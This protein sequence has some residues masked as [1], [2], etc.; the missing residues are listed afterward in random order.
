ME[1]NV[2]VASAKRAFARAAL[3]AV[4]AGTAL[5]ASGT[6]LGANVFFDEVGDVTNVSVAN[7]DVTAAV[8]VHDH[9]F[10]GE[11]DVTV[12][13]S[14]FSNSAVGLSGGG[15]LG[16]GAH[17]LGCPEAFCLSEFMI[18]Q[19]STRSN[20]GGPGNSIADLVIQFSSDPE[21]NNFGCTTFSVGCRVFENG[22]IQDVTSFLSLPANITSQ[23][24]SEA[25]VPEPATLALLGLGLAGL[26][27]SRRKPAK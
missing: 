20:G 24:R 16:I 7:F 22:N 21:V 23:F 15:T 10:G 3:P 12:T 13:G 18:T 26:A 9:R 4:F 14:F 17:E 19:W 8:I 6:A 1:V 27:A 25:P 2:Y 5:L 11:D